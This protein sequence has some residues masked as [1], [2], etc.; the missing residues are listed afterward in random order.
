MLWLAVMTQQ[1][2]RP[3]WLSICC[4]G[5]PNSAVTTRGHRRFQCSSDTIC[6]LYVSAQRKRLRKQFNREQEQ[7]HTHTQTQHI[8]I[9][10]VGSGMFAIQKAS[11]GKRRL[12]ESAYYKRFAPQ[13]NSPTILCGGNMLILW[14]QCIILESNFSRADKQSFIYSPEKQHDEIVNIQSAF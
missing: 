13:F 6:F 7:T 4:P 8:Y 3:A 5:S 12:C 2:G 11:F 1:S 10:N 14:R 9:A